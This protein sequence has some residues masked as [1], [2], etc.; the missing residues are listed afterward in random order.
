MKFRKIL[1]ATTWLI[2]NKLDL[3]VYLVILILKS[4]GEVG[5]A[6]S[7]QSLPCHM[8][9]WIWL[10]KHTLKNAG[11]REVWIGSSL[12]SLTAWLTL[13]ASSKARR[14]PVPKISIDGAQYLSGHLTST[15]MYTLYNR[16]FCS[17]FL[18]TNRHQKVRSTFKESWS[19]DASALAWGLSPSPRAARSASWAVSWS[20]RSHLA[21]RSWR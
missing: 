15:R 10:T 1:V 17:L 12:E 9:A 3:L 14:C 16:L 8:T 2:P 18:Y 7:V 11:T 5:T 21:R 4:Q 6:Q 19:W 20:T 13:S